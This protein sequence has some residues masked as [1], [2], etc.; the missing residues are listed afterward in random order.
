LL[1]KIKANPEAFGLTEDDSAS[2]EAYKGVDELLYT[3]MRNDILNDGKRIAGRALTEVREIE[4]ET[5][6]LKNH[7]V[8]HY[9]L[10][11]KLK[12]LQQ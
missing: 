7:M 6:V 12:F 1:S 11:V 8:L 9:L 4:T 2:K 3:L 5:S 10:E